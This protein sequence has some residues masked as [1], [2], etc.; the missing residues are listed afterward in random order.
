[1]VHSKGEFVRLVVYVGIWGMLDIPIQLAVDDIILEIS[2]RAFLPAFLNLSASQRAL[3]LI[4]PAATH[5]TGAAVAERFDLGEM[6]GT[7]GQ[8]EIPRRVRTKG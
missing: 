1:M 3:Q 4:F 6:D 2:V 7:L 5:K 8:E